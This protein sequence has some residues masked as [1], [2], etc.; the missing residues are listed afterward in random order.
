MKQDGQTRAV[1]PGRRRTG[2]CGTALTLVL[3]AAGAAPGAAQQ[4]SPDTGAYVL[5]RGSDTVSV[6]RFRRDGDDV[7][8]E[9]VDRVQGMR[10]T[11]TAELADAGLVE[12][13]T[14][15]VRPASSPEDSDPMQHVELS[16]AGDSVA[17]V[18]GSGAAAQH[19]SPSTPAGT[20]PFLNLDFVLLDRVVARAKAA[21]TSEVPMLSLAGLRVVPAHVTLS[22]DSAVVG[23]GGVEIR[24]ALDAA[25]HIRGGTVPAQGLRLERV[26]TATGA[27]PPP[28]DYSP[29]AGAPYEARE[30]H[31]PGPGGITLAGTL[32]MPKNARGPVPAVVT[33]TG[34]GP[35]ERD[36]RLSIV[37]GYAPFRQVA[38]TLGRRGIAV[39]RYDD[40]GFGGSTGDFQAATTADFAQDAAA[41]VAW[42]R[43]Q[44]EIDGARVALLGHSEGG[45][46]APLVAASDPK[47]AGIVLLAGPSRTGREI[48]RYQIRQSI[49]ADSAMPASQRDSAVGRIGATI[50][51][52][53]QTSVWVRHFLTYD[54]V[55]TAKRVKVPVLI[56]Q[57]G[58]DWQVLPAQADE[59]A[60]AF[61]SAGNGDVTER[62]FPGLNHLFVPDSVGN[63]AGY[64]ELSD[65]SVSASV[66]GTLADWLAKRLKR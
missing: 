4:A 66:L 3:L 34:S 36:E 40:R 56:L 57:G 1:E 6:E 62:V 64:A 31:F 15:D 45:E 44:P 12:R 54:P 49:D 26:A 59:L 65:R 35:E 16:F 25:G 8:A 10:Q 30:V 51:S 33:I 32:T 23:F 28:P 50:D 5:A 58:N 39:L 2:L 60:K 27:A 14:V 21:G 61:E 29:P 19:M 42:L 22:G 46:I 38:D 11:L 48:L 17:V 37:P 47:L 13:M 41:A 53:A 55:A 24:L 52:L 7:W 43:E 20:V 18:I 63:P 9:I